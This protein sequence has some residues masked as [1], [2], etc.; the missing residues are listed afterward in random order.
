MPLHVGTAC[1][2]IPTNDHISFKIGEFDER[3]EIGL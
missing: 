3:G 1:R 2:F